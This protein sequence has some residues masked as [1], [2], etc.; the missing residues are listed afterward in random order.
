MSCSRTLSS[1]LVTLRGVGD[2]ICGLGVAGVLGVTVW[3]VVV[4]VLGA[5][6]TRSIVAIEVDSYSQPSSG[7]PHVL[8]VID[9]E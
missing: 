9:C 8:T 5:R 6:V 1:L 3:C 7:K 4:V 2:W